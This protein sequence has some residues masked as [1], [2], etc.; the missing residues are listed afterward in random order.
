[1]ITKAG[2]TDKYKVFTRISS[3]FKPCGKE[4]CWKE[5]FSSFGSPFT[6]EIKN[7]IHF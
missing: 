2:S 6:P 3:F 7:P 5:K 1:M 4:Q